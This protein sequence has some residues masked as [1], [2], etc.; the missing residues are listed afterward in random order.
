MRLTVLGLVVLSVLAVGCISRP[1][2]YD[3]K[4]APDVISP[5]ADGRD[6]V[7]RIEY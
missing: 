7:T 4:V 6:D 2:L 1:L 3:V 5:N